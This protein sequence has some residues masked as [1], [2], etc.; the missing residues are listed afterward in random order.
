MNCKPGDLAVVVRAFSDPTQ[1][2][3]MVRVVEWDG[4]VGGLTVEPPII[5]NGRPWRSVDDCALRPI[6]PD[7]TPEESQDAMLLLT[8]IPQKETV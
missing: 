4:G 8:Q 2:G 3:K 5:T 6:R 7:E 1:L